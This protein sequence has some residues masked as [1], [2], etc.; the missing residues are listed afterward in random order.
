MAKL[1][2]LRPNYKIFSSFENFPLLEFKK[3]K[4]KITQ[5]FLEKLKFK[6]NHKAGS[7][8]EKST[9]SI[10]SNVHVNRVE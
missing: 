2:S 1:A 9:F 6:E 10:H 5:K 7:D 4:Y 8:F 3:K